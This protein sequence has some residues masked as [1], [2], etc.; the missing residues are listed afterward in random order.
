MSKTGIIFDIKEFGLHDGVGMRTTVFLKGCPLRCM[1]CH[2]PE[3]QS[4]ERE[5]VK[6]L[7]KCTDCGLCKKACSHD[8]C[9]D[10]GCCV[11]V[12]PNNNVKIA[13]DVFSP[14]DLAEKL[15]KNEHFL[16]FGGVT[17][18][19][20]EPL[21]QGEFILEVIPLLKG[22]R[23]AVETCGFVEED[24]FRR[25]CEKIDDIFM[26]I[27]IMDNEKHIY[28]TAQSNDPILKNAM[29]LME[30]GKNVT[31]RVPLIPSVTDTDENLSA[32]AKFL[33]PAKDHIK[34]ELIPYNRMT[35]AK[36]KNVGRVFSPEYDETLPLNKNVE[37]FESFGIEVTSY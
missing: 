15:L 13:G 20:G 30:S 29:W 18:S 5:L 27:K 31:F 6:N 32:I 14:A 16:R 7:N 33:S 4:F 12:C 17:F 1:W 3:G 21:C 23:T 28:Y 22:I 34:L 25:V 19:G 11:K 37:I 9:R 35:G 26:D 8:I 24:L 2:N 10:F 36:Y